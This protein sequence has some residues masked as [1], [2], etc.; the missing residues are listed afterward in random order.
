MIIFKE[1]WLKFPDAIADFSTRNESALILARKMKKMGVENHLFFLALHDQSLQGV[2]P[3]SPNLTEEQMTAIGMECTVN[4]W[5][6]FREVARA[7]ALAGLDGS[8]VEFNRANISLW[9]GFFN[10]I[11]YIL[12]QPRQTGKSFCTDLLMTLLYNFRCRNT[13]INL[14][15][16][17]DDLRGENILRLKA[18][19]EELPAYLNFK[20]REDVSNTEGLS[21]KKLGNYYNTHV[22]QSSEKRADLLGRG[23]TTGILHLD[24]PPFQTWIETAFTAATGAMGAAI[25]AAQAAGEPYGIIMTTT[26]GK[27]DD[28][29]GAFVYGLTEDAAPWTDKFYDAGN[30]EELEKLVR[31]HSRTGE[32]SVYGAF[33][34]K[35]LGKDDKWMAA[36]LERT[37]AKGDAANRDWFNVWTSG[38]QSA[39]LATWILEALAK[40]VIE[41]DAQ[42]ISPIGGYIVRWYVPEK[43]IIPFMKTRKTVGGFD[44]SDAVDKDAISF[45][46]T[47]VQTGG[48][49]AATAVSL[50][51]INVFVKWLVDLIVRFEN[52]TVIIER[53]STGGAI[54][55]I[56]LDVLPALGVDPFRRIFN[57]V[58]NNHLEHLDKYEEA[59]S[60]M[61]RRSPELYMR[62]KKFFGFATSG[63]GDAARNELYGTTLQNAAA[64]LNEMVHDEQLIKQLKSLV[65]KNGR[66][67][68]PTGGHD[69]MV[70][71]WLLTQWFLTRA[72]NLEFYGI[73]GQQVMK[74]WQ[75]KEET[76]PVTYQDHE[77]REI[78]NRIM[79][80]GRAL[81]AEL[82]SNVQATYERE[83][84]HLN[85]RLILKDGEFF[86]LDAMLEKA[87]EERGKNNRYMPEVQTSSYY[88]AVGYL[89]SKERVDG[90]S[91]GIFGR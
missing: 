64:Q 29:D 24:E 21:V 19:Y 11:T 15:T 6:F 20:T 66:I 14:L 12:I 91:G 56:L 16:K 86:S 82:D 77:Q 3:Y 62:S 27:K 31:M 88:E 74:A 63:S 32:Y 5:Y 59:K 45:V 40:N 53:R 23:L 67:D 34:Y 39:P 89:P 42:L 30:F 80:L 90:L 41:P 18:I 52:M 87:K 7:P 2:D 44:T 43:E 73:D 71:G 35:Q 28:R 48:V 70:I 37:K 54:L 84:R 46:L 1:D 78:R 25:A 81:A 76:G 55:D 72:R 4:P 50:T 58:V 85:A 33:S 26:A 61:S 75:E 38:S 13:K 9:W 57:W 79:E 49:V 68:H 65:T 10:H 83:M 69:D 36:Q 17:N 47:D 22:P 60:S 51:N 8:R